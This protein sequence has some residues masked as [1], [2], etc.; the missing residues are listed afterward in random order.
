VGAD[1]FGGLHHRFA[2]IVK[3]VKTLRVTLFEF[4]QNMLT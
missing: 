3:A 2:D 1:V 4:Q